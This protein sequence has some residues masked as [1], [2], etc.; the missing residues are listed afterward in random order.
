ML[1]VARSA[2]VPCD[3]CN[4]RCVPPTMI[5]VLGWCLGSFGEWCLAGSEAT[6]TVVEGAVHGLWLFWGG[7]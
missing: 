3:G 5:M 2:C 4:P 7:W 1:M 6:D